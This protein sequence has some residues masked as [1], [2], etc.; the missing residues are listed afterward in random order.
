MCTRREPNRVFWVTQSLDAA[1]NIDELGWRVNAGAYRLRF[2]ELD[3]L[4]VCGLRCLSNANIA[5][6][7]VLF[8]LL[9]VRTIAEYSRYSPWTRYLR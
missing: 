9:L 1:V 7:V 3:P 6:V 5:V 2:E 4:L 8:V